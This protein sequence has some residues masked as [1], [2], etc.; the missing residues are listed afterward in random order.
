VK[1]TIDLA[2]LDDAGFT[3]LYRKEIEP[4]WRKYE[5]PRVQAK[6]AFKQRALLAVP[7]AAAGG[8][9]AYVFAGEF[10]AVFFAVLVVA[11]AGWAI[12]MA[13]LQKVGDRAKAA[14]LSA[15]GEAIG[16]DYHAELQ[17]GPHLQRC[18]RLGLTPSHD[19]SGFKDH[20]VGAREGCSF[21]LYQAHLEDETRDKD[22][23]RSYTTVFRG[24]IIR[25]HFP[26]EFAGITVVRRDGGLLNL[27]GESRVD[28]Q[29]L[30]RV[31]LADP[32]F[33][34]V[35]E[36]YGS[37]QVEARYLVHPVFMER[38]MEI[39]TAFD[40]K[41]VR[42]AFEGGDL[43][44]AIEGGEKFKIGD[45]FKPLAD[46]ERARQ[47]VHDLASIVKLMDAVLTAEKGALL[48]RQLREPG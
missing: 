25:I 16:M 44:V 24:Q 45:L 10:S 42:C 3:G 23:D 15:I 37:D 46:P 36:V 13:P 20:F 6:A 1:E 9:L 40:G 28:G 27:F 48:A 43:L 11:V 26:K 41:R 7:A 31:G 18:Q 4:L 2:H 33:E 12:A 19:R 39:E 35:F 34:K 8:V 47:I 14:T 38:L 21:E 30:E 32:K 22:G 29:K 5:A 17:H